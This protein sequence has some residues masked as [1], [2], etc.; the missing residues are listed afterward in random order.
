MDREKKTYFFCGVGG[1][2]MSPLARLL[3]A[4]G[5]RVIG[6]DRSFDAGRNLQFFNQLKEE[7]I[8]IVR[9]D[10]LALSDEIDVFVYTR[11]V[12]ET[13]PDIETARRLRL[14]MIKR[15]LLM[16]QLFKNSKNIAVAG[17]SGKSTTTAMIGHILTAA[18]MK[19]TVINGAVMV[20]SNSNFVNGSSELVVF[21]A[22]E[23]DGHDDVISVCPADIA[24]LTN[25]SLDH[26][27][28]T[29]LHSIFGN[30]VK[31]AS[32]CAVLNLDC[33]SCMLLQELG[34]R[35]VTFG[36]NPDA[37]FSAAKFQVSLSIPGDHNRANALAAI[38]ACYQLGIDPDQSLAALSS[39][40]GI[41]RRLEVVREVNG[42][43]VVDDFASNPSKIAA[44]LRAV[45]PGSKRLLVIFQPHGFQP[46][47]MM[48]QGYI[49]T[50][51][52][53]LRAQ[54]LLLMPEIYYAGG[55]VNLV[56]GKALA[57][58]RDISSEEITSAVLKNGRN[59]HYLP[60]REKLLAFLKAHC[61]EGDVIIVM[62]SRDETLSDF[63]REIG[64][65]VA[66]N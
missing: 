18:G 50:F 31:K 7:G 8:T 28:L 15:P 62:G 9:Q 32:G 20:T 10:G 59:A 66:Q 17:T 49:E 13:N 44:S 39:F 65:L 58:P 23:S 45:M 6:S 26:F 25:M 63:A 43:R 34:G 4:R 60:S 1:N 3:V 56:A 11:A 57:I 14:P 16:A 29:E 12:E 51:S 30:F 33:C 35:V 48:K 52:A 27:E 42:I 2:G 22:D 36:N 37:D 5:S 40:E 64:E 47:K 53:L 55:T 54:D 24:V 21:E 38:A 41:K 19:P 46:A 61:Q